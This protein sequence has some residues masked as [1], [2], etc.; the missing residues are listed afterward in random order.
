MRLDARAKNGHGAQCIDFNG[1]PSLP[2]LTRQSTCSLAGSFSSLL[3][4]GTS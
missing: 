1:I 4:V 3:K 2:G